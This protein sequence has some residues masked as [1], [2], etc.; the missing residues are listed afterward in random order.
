MKPKKFKIKVFL[1]G[2]VNFQ[3][4]QNLNCRALSKH[5]NKDKF[6]V[7]TMLFP[8]GEA[9][10]FRREE[11]V[12]YLKLRRPVR[13]FRFWNYLKGIAVADVAYLPKGEITWFNKIVARIFNTKTLITVEGVIEKNNYEVYLRFLGSDEKI[14]SAFEWYDGVYSISKYM[15][16]R[17][18]E[19]LVIRS[20]GVLSLGV[21]IKTFISKKER[22]EKEL[23]DIIFIGSNVK[24]KRIDEYL[25]LSKLF[26]ELKFHIVGGD[27]EFKKDLESKNLKN[28]I[29]HGRLAHG[30]LA[31]LLENIDIHILPSRS[32][33]FPKVTLET[34]AS[35]VP[36]IVYGDYGADEWINTG[37]NGFVINK[38]EEVINIIID[39]KNNP[40]KLQHLSK[41]AVK[42]AMKFDWGNIIKDWEK[43]IIKLNS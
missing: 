23:S 20:D 37:E 41:N 16:S 36:S 4:A 33:G 18:K 42:L 2:Y 19:L 38:F 24:H 1:G 30:E 29:Y 26:P 40:N 21:E 35:G 15:A 7:T 12:R 27:D 17:N 28:V 14:R 11:N 8:V 5:L 25:E 43:A 39:L 32:E 6:E 13:L 22:K 34:A 3:N 31:K 10:D 9:K